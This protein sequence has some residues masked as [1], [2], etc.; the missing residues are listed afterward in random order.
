MKEPAQCENQG[1][2][3]IEILI[4]VAILGIIAAIA[5]PQYGQTVRNNFRRDIQGEM[6]QLAAE[7][8]Q[9]FSRG[10][11]FNAVAQY[12][13]LQGRYDLVVTVTASPATYTVTA[14]AKGPQIE[15]AGSCNTMTLDKYGNQTPSSCWAK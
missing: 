10:N 5:I 15:S 1:F 12:Q 13:A 4:V 6:L 8:E 14:T 2:T 9:G 11:G 3:L 7:Q